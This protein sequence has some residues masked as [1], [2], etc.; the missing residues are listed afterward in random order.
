MS[1]KIYLVSGDTLPYVKLTLKNADG[2][3]LDVSTAT[4]V[5]HFRAAGTTTVLSDLPCTK[6]NG[7]SDGVVQFNFPAPAL[8]VDPGLYEGEVEV[9]YPGNN[10]QTVYDVLK[11]QVRQQFA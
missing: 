7:G 8:S 4:V 1:D 10:R 3:V 11:F 6:P 9:I 5:V 2:T